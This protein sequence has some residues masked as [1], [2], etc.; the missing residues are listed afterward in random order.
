MLATF[1]INPSHTPFSAEGWQ[2]MED[3]AVAETVDDDSD[4][5]EDDE[6]LSE[7]V[8]S[9]QSSTKDA[10]AWAKADSLLYVIDASKI[11]LKICGLKAEDLGVTSILN[12]VKQTTPEKMQQQ[13]YQLDEL[14]TGKVNTSFLIDG[15]HASL[16]RLVSHP[17]VSLQNPTG[18]QHDEMGGGAQRTVQRRDVHDQRD[19]GRRGV[20]RWLPR[21]RP[22]LRPQGESVLWTL[23]VL[24]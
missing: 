21:L 1:R 17:V 20:G 10:E 3:D 16:L 18:G 19:V 14:V 12:I 22:L 23:A 9:R 15:G 2:H 5:D 24:M 7:I 13:A 8:S 4:S 6:G 11:F